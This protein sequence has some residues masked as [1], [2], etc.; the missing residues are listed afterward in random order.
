VVLALIVV[1]LT[2]LAF[3]IRYQG[4]D[5]RDGGLSTDEARLALAAQGVLTTGLPFLPSDRIYTRGLVTI[6]AMAPSIAAFG[7]H[8]WSARLPSVIA[9]AL[10]VPA[11]FLLGRAVAG[12]VPGLAVAAF[13][14]LAEPLVD[15]S[16]QAWPPA[17]FL[18]LFSLAAYA[19][20][21]GFAR[22]EPRW[23]PLAALGFLAT[24]LAYE[25]A[26]LLPLGLT[27]YLAGRLLRRDVG[28]W[29]GRWTLAALAIGALALGLLLVL[30]LALRSGSLAGSD[31]EFRHYF[32]PSL[33]P[34]GLRYY[35]QT[36]WGRYLAL[37]VLLVA[38]I[39]WCRLA[40]R[41][42]PPGLGFVLA[43][44]AAALIV[45]LFIIQGKQ[46]QQYGLAVVPLLGLT[47]AWGLAALSG[48]VGSRQ[49]AV[50][51]YSFE[52][53]C[54]SVGLLVGFGLV[55]RG[56]AASALH[57]PTPSH[58]STWIDDLRA[59][60]WQPTDLTFAEAPLVQQLYFGRADF[61]VQPDGFERY[62]HQDGDLIVSL[63][64]NAVLL[65]QAGDFER[66]VNSPY[67]GRTLWIVGHDDRLPRLTRQMDAALWQ[68]LEAASG[69]TRPTRGWWIMRVRLPV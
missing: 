10:L 66:L 35:V 45:P 38:G 52:L 58:A 29:R 22:D 26:M 42:L 55:L 33:A 27:L 20:Y 59:Q 61:Y 14:A 48:G 12:T 31:A 23:Q 8:D 16:R 28:W 53:V 68:R 30:G 46:E 9:G 7:L 5:R 43:L 1:L 18:L 36:L 37:L 51:R 2:G 39:V 57:P 50:G 32:T 4:L 21:R 67:A 47:A 62:A 6:Y 64:T 49:S 17:T 19:S 3:V 41:R 44:L 65:K 24:L 15:W 56:D 63:Y 25:L 69:V 54:W 13:V 60:G 40:R 34:S 11:M